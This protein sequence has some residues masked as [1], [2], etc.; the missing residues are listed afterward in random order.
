MQE[1]LG[2]SSS[3]SL[4]GSALRPPDWKHIR[5]FA[6][7]SSREAEEA[8]RGPDKLN[9]ATAIGGVESSV[10]AATIQ[11]TPYGRGSQ[12]KELCKRP[13]NGCT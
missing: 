10:Q 5:N 7:T 4:P 13:M 12:L 6:P 8:H 9:C 3:H 2:A 11:T 1:V